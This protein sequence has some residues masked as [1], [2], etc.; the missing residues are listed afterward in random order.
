[1]LI[2]DKMAETMPREELAKL[3]IK[4]LKKTIQ[5]ACANVPF[6][7]KLFHDNRIRQNDIKSLK[8]LSKIPF[9]YKADMQAS[10]PYGMFAL[11]LE[12]IVRIHSSSG[13]TGKPTV[14]GYSRND[15]DSWSE[16]IARL[17]TAGGVTKK[18]IVQIAF[19]YGLFTGGFGLHYGVEKIG[20]TVVPV[21]S[22]NTERQMMIMKDFHT[23][24]LV[25]TPSYAMYLGEAIQDA[26]INLKD[27]HLRVGL[28]G[29]EPWTEAMRREIEKKLHISATDNYGLSEVMGPGV[30]MEC[31][32]KHG[33]HI[34]EDHFIPEIIDP[35]SGEVLAYGQT[36][37]LALTTLTKEAIPLI[38]FRTRDIC[39]LIEEPCECGRTFIRMTKPHGRTDDM[40]IIRGVNVFPSQV[41]AILMEMEETAPHYQL[42]ITRDSALDELEIQ[43]EVNESFLSDEMKKMREIEEKIRQKVRARLGLTAYIRLVEPK[44]IE[45]SVGKAKRVID[46]RN[47]I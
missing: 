33:M 39:S 11:P 7:Q 21:S 28:F 1:L 22:G 38:R 19:G 16:L 8:D 18:D 20:A 5:H 15:L 31:Q 3:Q 34:N 14:V 45:R 32:V 44:T 17:L 36:G 12:G 46:K 41:E 30:S 24:A 9:T 40:L 2:W 43:V 10:Y 35:E 26:G 37:E 29:A 23:T 47:L 4:R 42:V 27:L 6:Y 13:T 25:C